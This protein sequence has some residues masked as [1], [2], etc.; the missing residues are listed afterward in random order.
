MTL[1]R[2]SAA[3]SRELQRR[4]FRRRNSNN[5]L[6][7]INQNAILTT[8]YYTDYMLK[9]STLRMNISI[10]VM[11]VFLGI[12]LWIDNILNNVSSGFHRNRKKVM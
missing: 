4:C 12:E 3:R 11:P 6:F 5:D 10:S 9:L 8:V 7:A 1:R 2:P